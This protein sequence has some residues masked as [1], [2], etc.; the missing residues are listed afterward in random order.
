[1]V[2]SHYLVSW[3][4]AGGLIVGLHG[5]FFL[6]IGVFGKKSTPWFCALLPATGIGVGLL[7][8]VSPEPGLLP[9]SSSPVVLLLI[10]LP[11]TA[12]TYLAA[13]AGALG[14]GGPQDRL[15][16]YLVVVLTVVISF[17]YLITVCMAILQL[18]SRSMAENDSHALGL[19]TVFMLYW[20]SFV[21]VSRLPRVLTGARLRTIGFFL[22]ALA[23]LTEFIPPVLDLLNISIR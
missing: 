19:A 18:L 7:L 14:S 10:V 8:A 5:F 4:Q 12:L 9:T 23:I 15:S 11:L 17:L 2:V 16:P 21:S 20:W 13:V 6:L 3:I 22:S 1:V